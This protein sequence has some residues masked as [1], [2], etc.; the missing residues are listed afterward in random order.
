MLQTYVHDQHGSATF[1]GVIL[2]HVVHYAL[3]ENRVG[4]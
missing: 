3:S 4:I 2:K 1:Q